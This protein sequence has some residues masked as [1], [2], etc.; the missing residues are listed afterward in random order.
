MREISAMTGGKYYR[1]IDEESLEN[2]Y[3]EIDTLEKTE[4]EINVFKRYKDEFRMFLV[5]G[6]ILL[7]LEFLFSK[8]ILRQIP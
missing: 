5:T 3:R 1:A 2:I 4:I 7:L 8:I 6:L